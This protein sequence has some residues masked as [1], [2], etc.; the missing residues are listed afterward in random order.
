[1]RYINQTLSLFAFLLL[2]ISFIACQEDDEPIFVVTEADGIAFENDFAGE[3]L[4]SEATATNVAERFVWNTPDFGAPVNVT[5][6]LQGSIDPEF[7]TFE[8]VGATTENNIA[9]TVDQL[10]DFA[11]ELGLDADP[12]TNTPDGLPNDAGQVF[13]RVF[14]ATGAGGE[15]AGTVTSEIEPLTIR[16]LESSA[17]CPSIYVVG[18]GAVDAGWGWGSPVEFICDGSTYTAEIN[19]TND[20]FRFFTE[21]GNWDSGLNFPYY[22]EEGYTID[23]NFENAEDGDLNFRFVGQPG[24]YTLTVDDEAK[25]ISLSPAE[26][27]AAYFLVGSAISASGWNWDNPTAFAIETEAGVFKVK[28]EILNGD[29]NE[30]AFRFFTEFGEWGSGLNYPHFESEGY[31]I[32]PLLVNAGDGD[33]NFKFMGD[34]GIYTITINTNDK[35]I[36]VE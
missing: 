5:Y 10:H 20:S 16:M 36:T 17:G 27:S 6:E 19:L 24:T 21:E 4:I 9:V 11:E 7:S 12:T 18:A 22:I 3:Y 8:V 2:S 23:P 31:T 26:G 25:T 14:A 15:N 32:D 35:V 29:G 1:M 28:T 13:F 34:T 30:N 33:S